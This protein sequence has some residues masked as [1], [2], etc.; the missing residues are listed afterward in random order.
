MSVFEESL[1]YRPFQFPW[2]VEAAKKHTIDLHWAEHQVTLQDDLIQYNSADGLKTE[3]VSHDHNKATLDMNLCLFTE[4]DKSVGQG[5][6]KLL[7]SIGNN[8]I[9]NMLITF[10]ARE[11]VHQRA[12]ALAAETFGFPDD[13][14]VMFRDYVEMQDK[15]NLLTVTAPVS[16][17]FESARLLTTILLGEGIALFAAF[18]SLLNLKRHGLLVGFNDVNQW[19]LVDEQEHVVNNIRV[20]AEMRKTLTEVENLE[21][22]KHI[23]H[24]VESYV[25]CEVRYI[26]LSFSQGDQ[27]DLTKEDMCGYIRYLGELR[28]YQ[29]ELLS[30]EKV[31]ENPL[32]WMTWLLTGAKHD[33]FFEKKV[34][35]Y[36]HAG[37]S[38]EVDYTKY[39]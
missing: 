9:R 24:M 31:R 1:S 11:V 7:H 18:A 14:W 35:D 30:Y 12:Y 5:Y 20:V 19:S 27:E 13:S 10:A 26:E 34:T 36:S 3:N 6:T 2:A 22:D 28:L 4:M 17:D 16:N 37:L 21:L 38:G 33:N 39:S 15:I 29:L 25:S 32:P 23:R 8:E